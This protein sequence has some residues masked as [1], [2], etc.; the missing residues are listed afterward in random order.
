M[1][2]L[3][4]DDEPRILDGLQR[5]LRPFRE[6]WQMSFA[7]SGEE[8]LRELERASF[9][10]V[11][12][13]M[14]MPKMD[15]P[16][17]LTIVAERWPR[18]L[19]IVLSGQTDNESASR[20]VR[21][22]HQFLIKPCDPGVLRR[23]IE[24][25]RMLQALLTEDALQALVGGAAALPAM[26]RISV[27]L[28]DALARP[29]VSLQD[30]AS[31]IAHDTGI[32]AK[33]L[34]IANSS[35]FGLAHRVVTVEQ[36]INYLGIKV[37]QSLV[38]AQEIGL[39][40]AASSA[41]PGFSLGDYQRH[42][43]LAASLARRITPARALRDE[44]FTAALLHDIG[45]LLLLTRE[46]AYF[47]DAI[48]TASRDGRPL[49]AVEQETRG[50]T[51]AE[52]GAYLLGIWALPVSI[53]E[54]VAHHHAPARVNRDGAD[55]LAVVHVANALAHEALGSTETSSACDREFL[56]D[57]VT[58]A[59]LDEW[60]VTARELAAADDPAFAA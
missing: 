49:Y 55:L 50:A 58:D 7:T 4:V 23:V 19:R 20:V 56:A 16:Q 48:A 25:Q 37:I 12:S 39:L 17:L 44:A 14:R 24:R 60:R 6:L 15:G 26:P 5:T 53:V 2:V 21:C 57:S 40:A 35:F 27:A 22:A 38:M 52:V 33:L 1:R 18:T 28:K 43:W 11:V 41:V 54:A 9:D 8:A 31:I 42:A 13:D 34:Q 30:L 29:D 36:A 51:H 46:P 32:T 3:F 47:A 10:V 59:Q 45:K